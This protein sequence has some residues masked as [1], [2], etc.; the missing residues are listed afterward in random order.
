M[1]LAV[2]EGSV[3]KAIS[4]CRKIGKIHERTECNLFIFLLPNLSLY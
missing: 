2:Y 3:F 4:L 1:I